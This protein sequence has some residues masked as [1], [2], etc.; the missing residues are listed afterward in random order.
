[1]SR[2]VELHWNIKNMNKI[3]NHRW[4]AG[5]IWCYEKWFDQDSTI[6]ERSI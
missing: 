5:C 2:L 3:R 4:K 6:M 1:M